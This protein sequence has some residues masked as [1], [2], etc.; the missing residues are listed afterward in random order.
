MTKCRIFALCASH[1]TN[2]KAL[3]VAGVPS[4]PTHRLHLLMRLLGQGAVGSPFR[5]ATQP[6]CSHCAWRTGVVATPRSLQAPGPQCC[7]KTTMLLPF[8][9]LF[10]NKKYKDA[11][12][13]PPPTKPF[14]TLMFTCLNFFFH[15]Q[16]PLYIK[17]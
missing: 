2:N 5:R 8:G 14:K 11:R 7:A 16:D 10:P 15:F 12:A 6:R 3:Q 4:T 1:T 9:A 13:P 17:L